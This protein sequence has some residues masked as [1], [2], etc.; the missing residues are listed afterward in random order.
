LATFPL[1][2]AAAA[3][4]DDPA[5]A[6]IS[7]VASWNGYLPPLVVLDSE[8]RRPWT[9]GLMGY[10]GQYSTSW[11]LVLAFIILTILSAILMFPS[12]QRDIVAGAVKG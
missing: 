8:S 4:A 9:L 3:R 2:R 10:Q 1:R 12:A 11:R 6:V 5:V 7:F